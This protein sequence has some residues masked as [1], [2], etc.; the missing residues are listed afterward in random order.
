VRALRLQ[1]IPLLLSVPAT[2]LRGRQL[3]AFWL[4]MVGKAQVRRA[5]LFCVCS[6]A[7]LFLGAAAHCC[8]QAHLQEEAH[9]SGIRAGRLCIAQASGGLQAELGEAKQRRTTTPTA[10]AY[11]GPLRPL[12]E[13]S[14]F[15]HGRP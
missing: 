9:L 13:G 14:C 12:E 3:G 10:K 8:S 1:A 11:A 4:C 6:G 2:C 5:A 15:G 7:G